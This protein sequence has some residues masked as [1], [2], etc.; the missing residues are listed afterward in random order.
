MN[1]Y[2]SIG[3]AVGIA[4]AFA[5]IWGGLAGFIWIVIFGGLGGL[6]GAHYE[7][8]LD[9]TSVISGNRRGGRG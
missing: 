4:I 1:N 9:L 2:T 6:I 8:R 3:L 5:I 7:G